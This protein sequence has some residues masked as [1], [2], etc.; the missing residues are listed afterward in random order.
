MKSKSK[1]MFLILASSM[2]VASTLAVTSFSS[3]PVDSLNKV[4]AYAKTSKM[5]SG[6]FDLKFTN[7]SLSRFHV[8]NGKI[9]KRYGSKYKLVKSSKVF[10]DSD[11]RHYKISNGLVKRN[12]KSSLKTVTG[13]IY[14][15]NSSLV[16]ATCLTISHGYVANAREM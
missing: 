8:K 1:K 10:K 15:E 16:D 6:A 12:Y 7:G 13:T 11:G 14:V 2:A 5:S 3:S 4:D 9:Y